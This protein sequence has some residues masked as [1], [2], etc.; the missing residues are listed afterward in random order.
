MGSAPQP[1]RLAVSRKNFKYRLKSITQKNLTEIEPS[2]KSAAARKDRWES[3]ERT[4]SRETS[5]GAAMRRSETNFGRACD[6]DAEP[7]ARAGRA[8]PLTA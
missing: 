6:G 7:W 8:A 5:S 3:S 2:R 1:K 4:A